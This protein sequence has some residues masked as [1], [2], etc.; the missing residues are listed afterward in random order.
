MRLKELAKDLEK[1]RQSND[2]KGKKAVE[3][4][5]TV[6]ETG[7]GNGEGAMSLNQE[8]LDAM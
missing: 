1:Q 7:K 3:E 8:E 2:V 5:S 6:Q 4:P